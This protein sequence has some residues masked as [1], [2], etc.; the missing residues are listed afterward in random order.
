MGFFKQYTGYKAERTTAPPTRTELLAKLNTITNPKHKALFT[1]LYLIGGRIEELVGLPKKDYPP[2]MKY[3]LETK[4]STD[5]K[6]LI[7][8]RNV[9]TLKTKKANDFRHIPISVNSEKEFLNLFN[10]YFGTLSPQEPLFDYSRVYV[11]QLAKKYFGKDWFPHWFRHTRATH[12][13]EYY[14]FETNQLVQFFGWKNV[15]R[16][17]TYVH[18]NWESLAQK[19][20]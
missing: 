3:Q 13:V 11:W 18:L 6:E 19:M 15:N 9:R 1:F 16:T 17:L 10:G 7:V 14:G 2:I 12:L 5:G 8:V 20:N 4:I